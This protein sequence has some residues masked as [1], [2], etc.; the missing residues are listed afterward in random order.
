MALAFA[1][2]RLAIDL[3]RKAG[4]IDTAVAFGASA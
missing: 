2:N 1:R 3:P 4:S